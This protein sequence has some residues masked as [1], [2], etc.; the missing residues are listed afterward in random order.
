LTIAEEVGD[1]E[2]YLNNVTVKGETFIRGGGKDSIYINGGQYNKITVQKTSSGNIRIV[3]T[4]AAGLEIIISEAAAGEAIILEG[5][6]DSIT[7]EADDV[8]IVTQGETNIEEVVVKEG[9]S[10]TL[11]S[12]GNDTII[13]KLV[14]D[15]RIGVEG[16]GTIIETSGKEVRNT[17]FEKTPERIT[18]PSS[19]GGG[20]GG[21]GGGSSIVAVSAINVTG[22]AVLGATL[23]AA[24]NPSNATGSYQWQRSDNGTDGWTNIGTNS[25]TY[26][27]VAGDAGKYIRVT[28]TATGNYTGQITSGAKEK[29]IAEGMISIAAIPGVT[30]PATGRM[31][32]T[33]I[34]ETHQYTGT[35][36]WDPA[37]NPF[38]AGTV[39]TANILLTAKAGWT[40]TGVAENFFTVAGATTTNI[41]D[42]GVVTAIFPSTPSAPTI[43]SANTNEDGT[44]IFMSFN[45]AMNDPINAEGNFYF[46]ENAATRYFSSIS[47]VPHHNSEMIL[48]IDDAPIAHGASLQ[49]YY[50]PGYIT[51]TDGG[52]LASVTNYHV[53]N[54]KLT[55]IKDLP[56]G[57]IV[58]D[59]QSYWQHRTGLN[60]S[61]TGENEPVE[62]IV[63][64]EGHY[65]TT[66]NN[67]SVTLLSNEMIGRYKYDGVPPVSSD[68]EDSELRNWLNTTF[69]NHFSN[70]FKD[71]ILSTLVPNK[72]YD[73]DIISHTTDKVFMPSTTELGATLYTYTRVV[74]SNWGYFTDNTS[75][76]AHFSYPNT[77]SGEYISYWTRS[78]GTITGDGVIRV[79]N[80]SVDDAPAPAMHEG[81]GVY[82]VININGNAKVNNGGE[83][84][85]W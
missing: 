32:V 57:T 28:F 76:R 69:Y 37:H 47:L 25:N 72:T 3:A 48:A 23:T 22:N 79:F 1:G 14:A 75:R 84:V 19:G 31:P 27:I 9:V 24:P 49:L 26:T 44:E 39:Y 30:A 11:V 83:I 63:V 53:N 50:S 13:T 40:L 36:T 2:V 6:F 7:I 21:G 85:V 51:S 46:T 78:P 55:A 67:D 12:L 34:I 8:N 41:E 65:S 38:Q 68:W 58:Y 10:G 4:N 59:S 42:T 62:W 66:P 73:S 5:S 16:E 52:S 60:Y 81:F 33:E 70:S 29:Q 82:P 71:N 61:G 45:K 56:T 54:N 15:A 17:I 35:V 20:G 80:G 43:Q 74:G 77:R 18:T 64:A